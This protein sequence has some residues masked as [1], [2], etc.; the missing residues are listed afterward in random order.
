MVKVTIQYTNESD[1]MMTFEV[2][3][4]KHKKCEYIKLLVVYANEKKHKLNK[5]SHQSNPLHCGKRYSFIL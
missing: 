1:D 3:T 4:L 5:N 2:D